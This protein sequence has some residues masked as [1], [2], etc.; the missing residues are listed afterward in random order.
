M[1]ENDLMSVDSYK[2]H[3]PAGFGMKKG[4]QK[5][6][7]MILP[8]VSNVC[9]S[10]CVHCWYTRKP[11]LRKRDAVTFMPEGLLKK[12]IE[13]VAGH[14]DPR[15]LIRVTGT[16]EP[17]LMPELTECLVYGCGEKDVRMAVISNGSLITPER[18]SRLIDAGIEALEIS[19]DAADQET[20][21]RIR[22]G[23]EF[24]DLM[25]NIEHMLDYRSKT[26]AKTK[27]LVSAVDSKEIDAS[28]VDLFW[29]DKVDNVIIRKYLTYGQLSEEGYSRDT[30][31]PPEERVPCPYPFERMVVL[32]DGNVTFCNFDVE[33]SCFM[34]NINDQTIE[35]I[36]RNDKFEAWRRL[37]L[38]G[39][40]EQVPLCAKCNDWKYKSWNYNFFS[41][42][43]KA[44]NRIATTN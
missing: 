33:D 19:A 30:Y 15:P 26:G 21:E 44:K 37:V 43:D 25:H 17:F 38:D 31:L 5:F 14:T 3:L 40:F 18:S 41:V 16:G 35:E 6:P 10:R 22:P 2:K 23:L 28:E 1:K 20:Y 8:S 12:I 36:W 11:G 32:A 24:K 27:I 39:R 34:G 29:R 4:A 9:N 42:L 7:L 13:E